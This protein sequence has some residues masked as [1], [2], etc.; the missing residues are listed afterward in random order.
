MSLYE[1]DVPIASVAS[2]ANFR[3]K[4][5][6]RITAMVRFNTQSLGNPGNMAHCK[7]NLA[8]FANLGSEAEPKVWIRGSRQ[9]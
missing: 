2:Y 8:A 1:V 6:E 4:E 3:V 5:K 9:V 7:H